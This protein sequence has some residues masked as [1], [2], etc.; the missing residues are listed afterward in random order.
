MVNTSFL[1]TLHKSYV[2]LILSI[3]FEDIF[4]NIFLRI[5]K[6]YIEYF[7]NKKMPAN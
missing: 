3:F 7:L 4:H 2:I 1:N 5:R 6:Q